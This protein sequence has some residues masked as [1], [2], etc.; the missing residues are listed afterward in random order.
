MPVTFL[1]VFDLRDLEKS[2]VRV[3][4]WETF[5][6]NPHLVLFEGYVT[7]TNKAFL[8]RKNGHVQ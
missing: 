3:E 2:G 6:E 8:E 7:K 1:R 4:S 5:E